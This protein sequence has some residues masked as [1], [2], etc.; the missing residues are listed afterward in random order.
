MDRRRQSTHGSSDGYVTPAASGHCCFFTR[1][2][3]FEHL[4]A[5]GI[6]LHIQERV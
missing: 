4:G 5:D 6:F 3:L 2:E 1:N